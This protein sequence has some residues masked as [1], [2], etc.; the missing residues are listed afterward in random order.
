MTFT[1]PND[2]FGN[3]DNK[4]ISYFDKIYDKYLKPESI[5][6][7]KEQFK[8][9]IWLEVKDDTYYHVHMVYRC[10]K[11]KFLECNKGTLKKNSVLLYNMHNLPFRKIRCLDDLKHIENC[12]RYNYNEPGNRIVKQYTF[13]IEK[14]V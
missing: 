3:D 4:A 7:T 2:Q 9:N 6:R 5:Y 13:E 1:S 10:K 12:I 14:V 11:G 8:A